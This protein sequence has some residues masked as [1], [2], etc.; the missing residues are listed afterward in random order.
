MF[1]CAFKLT[2]KLL[3][4]HFK[5]LYLKKVGKLNMTLK[6]FKSNLKGQNYYTCFNGNIF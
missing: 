5:R 2:L 1:Y 4:F 3:K 6:T